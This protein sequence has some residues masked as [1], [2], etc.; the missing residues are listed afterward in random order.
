MTQEELQSLHDRLV[1]DKIHDHLYDAELVK[2]GAG[3][4]VHFWN[5]E[6]DDE[7]EN[8]MDFMAKHGFTVLKDPYWDDND[9]TG[10]VVFPPRPKLC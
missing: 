5:A 1:N 7:L 6:E 2:L 3:R 9:A 4:F 10:W 8:A